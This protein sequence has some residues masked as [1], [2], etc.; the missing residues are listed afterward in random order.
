M[1][2]LILR[3]QK[4]KRR[5]HFHQQK[6]NIFNFRLC[7]RSFFVTQSVSRKKTLCHEKR[8]PVSKIFNYVE[9][10]FSWHR[11]CHEKRPPVS[12]ILNYFEGLFSW[13]RVCGSRIPRSPPGMR[14]RLRPGE[15][16]AFLKMLL[17]GGGGKSIFVLQNI[18]GENLL[19]LELLGSKD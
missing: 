19:V 4:L 16:V 1:N 8:P 12:K 5:K 13:H 7:W 15:I 18:S 14:D 9:G 3:S 2:Y 17:N 10:L 6:E 11:V